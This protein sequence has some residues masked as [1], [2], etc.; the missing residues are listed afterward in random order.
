MRCTCNENCSVVCSY[1][2][3]STEAAERSETTSI[4]RDDPSLHRFHPSTRTTSVARRTSAQWQWQSGAEYGPWKCSASSGANN[5]VDRARG[6]LRREERG[7]KGKRK[8]KKTKTKTTTKTKTQ[9][10]ASREEKAKDAAVCRKRPK[11]G[12]GQLWEDRGRNESMMEP[13]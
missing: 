3:A 10:A 11:R 9:R 1:Y 13:A 12:R 8:K 2:T 4:Y 7:P 6:V 5:S